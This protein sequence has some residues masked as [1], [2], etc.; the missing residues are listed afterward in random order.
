MKNLK[1]SLF[2]L[3]IAALT[4]VACNGD[5]LAE[6]EKRNK[7]LNEQ[8][9][10]QD[11]LLNDFM[12][13]FNSFEDNL[14]LIKE[15]ENLISMETSDDELA[16]DQKERILTDIQMINDLLDQNR[17]LI[18][19]LTE[20]VEG[21]D[22]K[23]REFRRMVARLKKDL[24]SRDV[25]INTMKEELVAL[26]FEKEELH[27]RVDTLQGRNERLVALSNNQAQTIQ[28][29]EEVLA[30]QTEEINHQTARLNQAFYV[31]GTEKE[32][33]AMNVL[34]KEG[35]LIGI[36]R[37]AKLAHNFDPNA[38]TAVDIT[39]FDRIPVETKKMKLV[40]AHPADAYAVNETEKGRV[41]SLEITDPEK[42]WS[43][44]R[45]LVV[46]LN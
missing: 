3:M 33:K 28:A 27:I 16:P 13:S 1:I 34:E 29:K 19:E 36:G 17:T 4:L 6:L 40:T 31:V 45:Y 46:V 43:A 23:V 32:L 8:T 44:S 12:T 22:G 38:F 25:E 37:T 39:D 35:G 2:A 42:F 41:E 9:A 18:A 24:E 15:K 10:L 7:A 11:S 5:K 26:N 30:Q 21:N 20:K 14:S